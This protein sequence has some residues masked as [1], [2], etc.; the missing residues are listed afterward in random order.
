[1]Q[2][3]AISVFGKARLSEKVIQDKIIAMWALVHG[4]ASI[5][6]M[7]NVEFDDNW[8]TRVGEIIKSISIPYQTQEAGE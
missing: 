3:A 4:L 8:E 6:V 7:P 1:M 5:V 2:K